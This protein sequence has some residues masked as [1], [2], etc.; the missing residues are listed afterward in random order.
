M[1][2]KDESKSNDENLSHLILP[3]KPQTLN[4]A[5]HQRG[6]SNPKPNNA[7]IP[8]DDLLA[9]QERERNDTI[10]EEPTISMDEF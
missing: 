2:G 7:A 1:G 6:K 8:D 5:S 3:F 10:P 9:D 4:G